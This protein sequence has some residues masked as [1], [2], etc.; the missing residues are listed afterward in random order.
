MRIIGKLHDYYDGVQ[1]L[2]SD[3]TLVFHRQ[4]VEFETNT[5]E[6][7]EIT[8]LI[9]EKMGDFN[10]FGVRKYFLLS[11][12][13]VLPSYTV[14]SKKEKNQYNVTAFLICF[15][16]KLYYGFKLENFYTGF[17]AKKDFFIYTPDEARALEEKLNLVNFYDHDK[18]ANLDLDI[19]GGIVNTQKLDLTPLLVKFK[20]PYFVLTN[21]SHN[22]KKLIFVPEL[23][24]YGF[25]KVKDPYTAYQD[26]S[27]FLGGVIPRQLPETVEVSDA[28]RIKQHGFDKLSFRHPFKLKKVK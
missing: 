26:L 8:N 3:P 2:G 19:L 1:A 7:I 21:G 24:K 18:P 6:Y 10:F 20:V 27:M 4:T 14:Y 5:P 13:F 23:K 11:R 17:G 25:Q 22:E 12:R 9:Q 15:C 28:D 16:G